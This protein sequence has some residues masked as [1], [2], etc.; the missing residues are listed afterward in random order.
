MFWMRIEKLMKGLFGKDIS[1]WRLVF[2]IITFL[3]VA[4]SLMRERLGISYEQTRFIKYG[5]YASVV[6]GYVDIVWE[7]VKGRKKAS[8][9]LDEPDLN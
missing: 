8:D 2:I 5:I 4:I 7:K 6:L 9:V 1:N 3:G